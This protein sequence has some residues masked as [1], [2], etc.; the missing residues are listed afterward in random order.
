M[1]TAQ[2]TPPSS[3]HGQDPDTSHDTP[4]PIAIWVNLP[5]DGHHLVSPPPTP[6]MVATLPTG[7]PVLPM[8]SSAVLPALRNPSPPLPMPPSLSSPPSRSSG[9]S[10]PTQSAPASRSIDLD[11]LTDMLKRLGIPP[12]EHQDAIWSLLDR[13]PFWEQAVMADK[14]PEETAPAHLSSANDH[15]QTSLRAIAPSTIDS[16]FDIFENNSTSAVYREHEVHLGSRDATHGTSQAKKKKN[17]QK[18]KKNEKKKKSENK[19]KKQAPK[20]SQGERQHPN[21]FGKYPKEEALRPEPPS[22]TQ[23]EKLKATADIRNWDYDHSSDHPQAATQ[24]VSLDAIFGLQDTAPATETLLVIER[25]QIDEPYTMPDPVP[26]PEIPPPMSPSPN[27]TQAAPT[28]R[29]ITAP[30]RRNHERRNAVDGNAH[31]VLAAF[32][33]WLVAMLE[34]LGILPLR[35]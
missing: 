3:P 20:S 30:E 12:D 26:E 25:M 1:P 27:T 17:N 35:R 33:I 32:V 10:A 28:T 6:V 13:S 22:P 16:N 7:S 29:L 18:R 15:R 19:K 2:D 31:P 21:L 24:Y 4:P 8:S 34:N 5:P 23:S 9:S 14:S 11:A